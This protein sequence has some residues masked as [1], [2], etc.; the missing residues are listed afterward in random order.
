MPK[1]GR[2]AFKATENLRREVEEMTSCGMAED[3]IARAIGCS[4]PTLRT[5]FAEELLIGRDTRRREVIKLLFKS[6]R[7]GNVSAQK[8]LEDMTAL[9]ATVRPAYVEPKEPKLGKKE[10]ALRAAREPNTDTTLGELM[11]QRLQSGGGTLN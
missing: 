4:T 7:S 5:Y 10:E 9:T 11:A 6:A 2:P 1:R 3:N 8:K